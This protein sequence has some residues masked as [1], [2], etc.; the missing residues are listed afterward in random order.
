MLVDEIASQI[1]PCLAGPFAFFG[2]SMGALVGFELLRRLQN[3][4]GP[5][6]VVF[7]A[8]G[9]PAPS[10]GGKK[11]STHDLPELE[12]IDQLRS[13]KGTPEEVLAD[14]ELLHMILPILRADFEA[15]Q[16]Y[17]YLPGQ[18]LNCPIFAYGGLADSEVTGES[19][20]PWR[21]ETSVTF[22]RRMFPGDHF[23]IQTATAMVTRS[24]YT[25]LFDPAASDVPTM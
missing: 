15:S 5:C 16:T 23:F 17:T 19:L 24:I 10:V 22:V 12:F 4:N 8:S 7:F 18:R 11:R 21:S 13:L 20:D 1:L 6:P 25:D 3:G 9:C 14:Q 2:H